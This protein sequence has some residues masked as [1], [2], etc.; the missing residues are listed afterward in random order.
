M[1]SL[2]ALSIIIFLFSSLSYAQNVQL[3]KT[4]STY[5]KSIKKDGA[6]PISAL[7]QKMGTSKSL[8]A[9]V[10]GKVVEVCT[11]KGCWMKLE[12]AN[13]ESTRVTFKDYAFF[14]PKNIVGKQVVLEGISKLKTTSVA[15]LQHFAT[16]AGKSKEEI[17]KITIPK[18]EI[19]FEAEGV[20]VL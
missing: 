1:K 7:G 13:G 16:D 3:A 2:K 12:N 9:K 8:D 10:T 6:F 15:E 17:A 14:M 11:S 4:G 20:L 19:T 18:T 5:G